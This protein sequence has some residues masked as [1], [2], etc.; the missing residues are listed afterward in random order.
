LLPVESFAAKNVLHTPSSVHIK[1]LSASKLTLNWSKVA[2]A[3][4]Y[5][6]FRYNPDKKKYTIK[7]TIKG[8]SKLKWT[9]TKLTPNNK[10]RYKIRAYKYDR[11]KQYSAF[12]YIVSAVTNTSSYKKVNASNIKSVSSITIGLREAKK[13]KGEAIPSKAAKKKGK[14]V[15]DKSVRLFVPN[16]GHLTID[17]NGKIVGKAVGNTNVYLR[18]HNGYLKKIKV[19]IVDYAI[20]SKWNNLDEIEPES[21][22]ILKNFKNDV[23]TIAAYFEQYIF[24][25]DV[26]GGR[27]KLNSD[28]TISNENELNYEPI[29]DSIE[30]LLQNSPY[31]ISIT[32]G[33]T[34]V[35]FTLYNIGESILEYID[36]YFYIDYKE[37]ELNSQ[38]ETKIAPHWS[39]QLFVGV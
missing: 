6:I 19:K 34:G 10:Y 35:F 3:S 24:D 28:G 17:K 37:D 33:K 18:A 23:T 36:F 2:G 16:T 15:I 8:S 39:F 38:W 22:Y 20:P 32:V 30:H 31:S 25:N 5:Q 7:K 11:K 13:V 4:G 29:K 14:K 1:K 27:L 12:T 9:D 21:R 26:Y